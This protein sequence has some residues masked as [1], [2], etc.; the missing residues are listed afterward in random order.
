MK[1]GIENYSL[2]YPLS[3]IASIFLILGFYR[4]GKI[5]FKHRYIRNSLQEIC[6]LNF[7]YIPISLIFIYLIFYPLVLFF[8]IHS[9]IF[10]F[11]SILVLLIGIWHFIDKIKNL[12]LKNNNLFKNLYSLTLFIFVL[13]YF[14]LSLGPITDA[15]SLDYHISV[16]IHIINYGSFPKD[17]SWFHASQAGIGE[18]PIIL[19]LIIGA[20]QFS[21]L[22]Q[23]SGFISILGVI[24][25]NINANNNIKYFKNEFYLIL[26]FL[27]IPLLIFLNSTAKPQLIFISYSTLA[28][29]ITFFNLKI[30][31]SENNFYKFFLITLLLYVCFEGKFSFIL[32]A[33]IISIISSFKILK[34]KNYKAFIFTFLIIFILSFPSFYWKYL[35][36][37]G[38]F[39]NKIYFPYFP[40]LE[41]YKG[42]YNSI[43]ACEF[44]CNKSFF[45]F[46][47]SLGRYTETIGIAIL[48]IPLL[49]F[50]NIKKNIIIVFSII[51]YFL[52]LYNYGKFS[53]RFI[54]EP[55]IWSI[56]ALKHSKFNFDFKFSRL[57][58]IYIFAQGFLTATA[59]LVGIFTISVGSLSPKLKSYVLNNYAYG[60][61]LA[62]WSSASLNT[63]NKVI[64]SHRSISLPKMNIIPTDF[65]LYSNDKKYLNLLKEKKPKYL[66]IR[67]DSSEN[68]KKLISCTS[69]IYKKKENFFKHKSRNFFNKSDY[70]YSAYIYYFDYNKLPDCYF[71]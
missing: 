22:V 9:D 20:E 64:Y 16:P 29:A 43:N 30:E 34:G 32:S 1:F 51:F 12:K 10:Y 65:L 25:K 42:L 11:T 56:I 67:S 18:I 55:V 15:D 5:L 4:I 19:G 59:V 63:N 33:F 44:P 26:I 28:F 31:K 13:L 35:N 3:S 6:I 53:A 41:G 40:V 60:Y 17:I 46:P 66:V 39:I 7:Q 37:G 48:T 62:N 21:A 36:Y 58:K 23:F 8:N 61:D 50:T 70:K 14:F 38:N 47:N 49:L 24:K 69:G 71:K 27:S 52:I 45:L 68:I 2:T 54:I 57:L